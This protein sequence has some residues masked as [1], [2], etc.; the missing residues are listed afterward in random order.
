MPDQ[1][2]DREQGKG[3]S[4]AACQKDALRLRVRLMVELVFWYLQNV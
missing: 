4:R 1:D 3:G 2:S